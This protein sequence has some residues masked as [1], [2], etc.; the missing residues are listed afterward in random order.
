MC[1]SGCQVV[2]LQCCATGFII[3]PSL[4]SAQTLIVA[5]CEY[6]QSHLVWW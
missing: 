5:Q 2:G 4:Q 1:V 3:K 6:E